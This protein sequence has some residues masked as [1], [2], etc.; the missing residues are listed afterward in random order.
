MSLSLVTLNT[1]KKIEYFEKK[2]NSKKYVGKARMLEF[3]VWNVRNDNTCHD[4][5]KKKR[6][7]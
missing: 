2:W 3:Y 6:K 7:R 4:P 5:G 1:N